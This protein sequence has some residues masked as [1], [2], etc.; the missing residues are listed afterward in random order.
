M[1]GC[2]LLIS[3][4]GKGLTMPMVSIT[5]PEIL[6]P[7]LLHISLPI[8]L[9]KGSSTFLLSNVI[10]IFDKT[11]IEMTCIILYVTKYDNIFQRNSNDEIVEK[12][13]PQVC[14]QSTLLYS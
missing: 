3:Y 11:F 6:A 8:Y 2:H 1:L 13:C 9:R 14:I 10:I 4:M 5:T 7:P 12:L